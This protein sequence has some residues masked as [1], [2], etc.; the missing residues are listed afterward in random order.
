MSSELWNSDWIF[1]KGFV[2]SLIRTFPILTWL[3]ERW[4]CQNCRCWY[5]VVESDLFSLGTEVTFCKRQ[6]GSR[7]LHRR[8]SSWV[9]STPKCLLCLGDTCL[10]VLLMCYCWQE[11]PFQT[12][13]RPWCS[14]VWQTTCGEGM[15][16]QLVQCEMEAFRS[17]QFLKDPVA[18]TLLLWQTALTAV[19]SILLTWK[20]CSQVW[21]KYQG[22]SVTMHCQGCVPWHVSHSELC[23]GLNRRWWVFGF[24]LVF[25]FFP[26][27]FVL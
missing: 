7:M 9:L 4:L 5:F 19:L 25:S 16:A 21:V 24:G 6:R 23:N 17:Q 10:A 2:V 1:P 15:G 12:T 8:K 22:S 14:A 20:A 18:K 3:S 26:R 11:Q 27:K 13:P